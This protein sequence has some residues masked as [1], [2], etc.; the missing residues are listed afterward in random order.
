MRLDAGLNASSALTVEQVLVFGFIWCLFRLLINL[1]PPTRKF[2]FRHLVRVKSACM[3]VVCTHH[4]LLITRVS[5]DP[6]RY[7]P[8]WSN[9]PAQVCR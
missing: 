5:D 7:L 4:L 8:P 9:Y 2:V 6:C 3:L 1:A